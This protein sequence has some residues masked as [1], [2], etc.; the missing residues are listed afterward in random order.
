[1]NKILVFALAL[2]LN[3]QFSSAQVE[4]VNYKLA[5]NNETCLFDCYLVVNEGAAKK[6]LHRAQF[7]A[8]ITLVAP[9]ESNLFVT[10]SYM[11]LVDNQDGRSTKPA[12][13]NISNEV[14]KPASLEDSRLVSIF[15]ELLPAAFYNEI[16]A[17]D[18]IKLFSFKVTPTLDC[19]K[20]VR[21]YN[22]ASDPSS[23]TKGMYGGDF[24][25]G[26]TMGG[27]SQKYADN[28]ATV[29]PAKPVIEEVN[30]SMKNKISLGVKTSS[31]NGSACQKDFTYTVVAP[32]GSA[33]GYDAF[34][35]S[36]VEDIQRGDYKVIATD[37]LGC[38]AQKRFNP[39][40]SSTTPEEEVTTE[41]SFDSGIYPN[42]AQNGIALTLNG[43]I[44]T[45][46]TGDIVNIEGKV[47][48]S[49]I[50]DMTMTSPVEVLNINTTLAPGMYNI[51]LTLNNVEKVNHKL[52]IIK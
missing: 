28:S 31:K 5:Y 4:S 36:K 6:T 50:V 17:G 9:E 10:E 44:G 33:I 18:E 11:P 32:D 2:F 19:A 14:E 1:M 8:Q 52:L 43:T 27:V 25:N 39:F 40:G 47:V 45:K 22:N 41:L 42:P 24:R 30:F 51:S 12:Q 48:E 29:F 7:N 34:I 49:N 35:N 23:K 3:V 38:S 13:W 46:V 15:P 37:N 16:N 20:D 26:F 21:L